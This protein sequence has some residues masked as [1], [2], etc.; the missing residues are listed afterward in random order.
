M[1]WSDHCLCLRW[2]WILICHFLFHPFILILALYSLLRLVHSWLINLFRLGSDPP[3]SQLQSAVFLDYHNNY[4]FPHTMCF[5]RIWLLLATGLSPYF[6]VWT[7]LCMVVE[8]R[9]CP[10]CLDFLSSLA[11]HL[12]ASQLMVWHRALIPLLFCI[13]V[14][15]SLV[16][17]HVTNPWYLGPDFPSKP[18]FCQTLPSGVVWCSS[19][20]CYIW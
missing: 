14:S 11:P 2:Y 20:C 10:C 1:L 3:P 16:L 19:L 13:V 8:R 5:Y 15:H 18:Q 17:Y 6:L 7:P 12:P 4:T 9:V